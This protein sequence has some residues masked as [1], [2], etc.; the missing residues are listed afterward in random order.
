MSIQAVGWD[1]ASDVVSRSVEFLDS[2]EPAEKTG[3]DEGAD[4]PNSV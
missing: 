2:E 4:M 3:I 1:G